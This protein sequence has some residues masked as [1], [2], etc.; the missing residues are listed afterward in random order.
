MLT[1]MVIRECL[2]DNNETKYAL[3]G[4][5]NP[6][7]AFSNVMIIIMK[8]NEDYINLTCL[9]GHL[10]LEQTFKTMTRSLFNV[11]TSNYVWEISSEI[12][13]YKATKSKVFTGT[14]SQ[15]RCKI[16]KLT[17]TV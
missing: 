15:N 12:H 3:F 11:F 5:S 1:S 13:Q 17:G 16:R 9:N 10:F 4:S 6:R 14:R 2:T 7:E 8:D